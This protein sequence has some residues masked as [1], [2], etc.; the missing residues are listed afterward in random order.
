MKAQ[1]DSYT[2]TSEVCRLKSQSIVECRVP[3]LE[4]VNVLATQAK[5]V[6]IACECLDGEVKYGGKL[7]VSIVYEDVQKKIC[8]IERGA[9]FYHK[10]DDGCVTPACFGQVVF[11]AENITTRREGTGL[12]VSVVVGAQI[13]VFGTKTRE[14]LIGGENLVVKKKPAAMIKAFCVSG[15]VQTEDEFDTDYVGDILLH[16]ERAILSSAVAKAG[17]IDISGEA[18]VNFCVLKR[19]DSLCSYE[20][21][22]PFALQ[23][24]CEEAFGN[25]GV[26]VRLT[27]DEITINAAC[28][29]ERGVSQMNVDIV[30][31]ADCTVYVKEEILVTDDAFSLTHEITLKKEKSGGRYLTNCKRMVEHVGGDGVL[32]GGN[33]ADGA[34]VTA[35]APHAEVTCRKTQSGGEIEGV[36]QA[37]LLIKG[38]DGGYK[39]NLLSLPFLFPIGE[40]DDETEAEAVVSGVSIRKKADGGIAAEGTLKLFVK[41]Y[42][43]IAEEYVCQAEEGEEYPKTNA[44]FQ[45]FA[46]RE[47][48]DLWQV[49]KRLKKRTEEVEKCNPDL[50][51]PIQKGE[52]IFIYTQCD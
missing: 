10:A 22:I 43:Q 5:A 30:V 6:A 16:S 46:P 29:E 27:V 50:R 52:K 25:V 31:K 11:H 19:D 2:Y 15:E 28:D 8:R 21:F 39:R 51:F 32:L 35:F 4:I 12:Y 33:T 13:D 17:Q 24:P 14:Y 47:G 48:E 3:G 23:I 41:T 40:I 7:I 20:R 49:A 9:E 45:I 42:R 44:A 18:C 26:G 1:Y 36:L 34:L 37:D 38:E